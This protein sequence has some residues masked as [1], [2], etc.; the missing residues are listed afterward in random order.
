M[1]PKKSI[2]VCSLPS[3]CQNFQDIESFRCFGPGFVY[4]LL[5]LQFLLFKFEKRCEMRLELAIVLEHSSFRCLVPSK[6]P[7]RKEIVLQLCLK[8][9]S[10]SFSSNFDKSLHPKHIYLNHQ[11]FFQKPPHTHTHTHQ[12]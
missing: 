1:C 9:V 5:R 3:L 4:V 2:L 8:A 11:N 7:S 6:V 12:I 10:T